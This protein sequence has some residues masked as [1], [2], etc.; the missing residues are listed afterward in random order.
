M[1]QWFWIV[2]I[3]YLTSFTILSDNPSKPVFQADRPTHQSV[4]QL[5]GYDWMHPGDS[6]RPLFDTPQHLLLHQEMKRLSNPL[7]D[8]E[9]GYG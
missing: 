6:L 2:L 1:K 5:F 9:I 3:Y 7:P 4:Q 8:D